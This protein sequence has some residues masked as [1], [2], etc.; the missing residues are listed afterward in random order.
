MRTKFFQ[1]SLGKIVD[2]TGVLATKCGLW[3]KYPTTN[4]N[5]C[6]I[7]VLSQHEV[8][9]RTKPKRGVQSGNSKAIVVSELCAV[10]AD[11]PGTVQ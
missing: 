8:N 6:H 11:K 9:S 7:T 4:G 1:N 3:T 5:M 10:F 2:N